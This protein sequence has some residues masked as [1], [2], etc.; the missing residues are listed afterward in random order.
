MDAHEKPQVVVACILSDKAEQTLLLSFTKGASLEEAP[1]LT[2][3]KVTLFEREWERDD[4]HEV[5]HFK[6]IQGSEWT[7]PFQESII[8]WKWRFPD[9]T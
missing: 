8:G 6:R 3:A 7:L 9:M 1:P 5:G 4:F 2:E